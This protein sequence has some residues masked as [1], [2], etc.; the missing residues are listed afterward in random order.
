MSRSAAGEMSEPG[1]FEKT[2]YS[3]LDFVNMNHFT[4][5]SFPPL[6]SSVPCGF[7]P[8]QAIRTFQSCVSGTESH[9]EESQRAEM[10]T[11]SFLILKYTFETH[12]RSNIIQKRF[13]SFK[14]LG[15]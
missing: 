4:P 12:G 10:A 3:G 7:S 9:K 2:E 15:F 5:L 14:R 6:I 1:L 11:V 13:V 8:V